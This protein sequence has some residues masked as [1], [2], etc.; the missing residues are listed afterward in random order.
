MFWRQAEIISR[1]F[2]PNAEE[3]QIHMLFNCKREPISAGTILLKDR[4][5]NPNMLFW[6]LQA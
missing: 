1:G 2:Y 5:K 3:S 4:E 6:Y